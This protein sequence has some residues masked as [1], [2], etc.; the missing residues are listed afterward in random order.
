MF[1]AKD[2]PLEGVIPIKSH[3]STGEPDILVSNPRIYY[4]ENTLDYVLVNTNTD[5]LDCRTGEGS[6]VRTKYAGSGGV[7]LNS[8]IKRIASAWEFA[9][10]NI[11]ISGELTWETLVQYHRHIQDR[12]RKVVPFLKLD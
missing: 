9:D 10:I 4:G 12:V 5:E 8:L 3:D 2:I 1:F 7:Q 6:L 11:L